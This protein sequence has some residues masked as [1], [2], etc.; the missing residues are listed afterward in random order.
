VD[1][2]QR[3]PLLR[4]LTIPAT[5]LH[6]HNLEIL[7][8]AVSPD[9]ETDIR[10]LHAYLIP[11]LEIAGS[12]A[13]RYSVV[14]YPVHKTLIFSEGLQGLPTY[15]T[16]A[17]A[18][19]VEKEM[20]KGVVN[21]SWS[22]LRPPDGSDIVVA[23]N[24]ERAEAAIQ[25]FRKSLGNSVEYE[26]AWFDSGLPTLSNWV[27]EGS[28]PTSGSVKPIVHRLIASLLSATEIRIIAEETERLQKIASMTIPTATRSNLSNLISM[29]SENAHTE[30]RDQLD[31]AFDSPGWRKLAWWKL[32][33]RV[34]DVAMITTDILS[35]SWLT[36]AE[37]ELIWLAGRVEQAGLYV[38]QPP[39]T[40]S[41]EVAKQD[42][43][44][45]PMH[46][47]QAAILSAAVP[48]A[49]TETLV[50]RSALSEPGSPLSTTPKPHPQAL[51]LARHALASTT[52][53]SLQAIAQRLLLYSLSATLL[54]ST[55]S[56]LMYISISTTS[57]YE[58]GTIAALGLVYAMRRLQNRWENIRVS[59]KE[60]IKEQGRTTLRAIERRWSDLIREGGKHDSDDASLGE[61]Q[62]AREAVARVRSALSTMGE[63]G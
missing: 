31:L 23:V 28:Q 20:I 57:V 55:L 34:D 2:N 24:V 38:P 41:P 27:L 17:S 46:V 29:W 32:P 7:I 58:A 52:A 62:K 16:I 12:S 1:Y 3:Y 21:T 9:H 6:T 18:K 36:S 19:G 59:W 33:W 10:P 22:S 50:P 47:R 15:A 4:T 49:T 53:P 42:A 44:G 8:Q 37:K 11:C 63:K 5:T 40:S 54:T 26:H 45:E 51:T 60:G 39:I 61:R 14:R 13:A 25:T 35:R 56:I 30:L 48:E 43:D